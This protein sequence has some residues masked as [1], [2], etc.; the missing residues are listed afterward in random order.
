METMADVSVSPRHIVVIIRERCYLNA[1]TI[2]SHP[3]EEDAL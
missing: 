1:F 3:A 2:Q